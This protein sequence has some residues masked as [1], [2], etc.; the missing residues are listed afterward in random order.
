MIDR[1]GGIFENKSGV[2]NG[3]MF[4]CGVLNELMFACELF[5]AAVTS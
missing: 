2:L 3:L 5:A 4:A 1:K